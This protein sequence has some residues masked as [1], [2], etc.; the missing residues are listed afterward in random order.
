MISAEIKRDKTH[1]HY[2]FKLKIIKF[3]MVFLEMLI[4]VVN[5]PKIFIDYLKE[6]KS[7]ICNACYVQD[8]L[9]ND[10]IIHMSIFHNK[11]YKI[12]FK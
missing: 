2:A 6:Q 5:V 12:L 1:G 9:L 7:K 11:I 10:N 4:E 3:I 8:M